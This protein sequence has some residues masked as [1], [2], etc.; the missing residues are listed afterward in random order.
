MAGQV[1]RRHLACEANGAMQ[2][3][4]DANR[5]PY[6]ERDANGQHQHAKRDQAIA[7]G[8]VDLVDGQR[9]LVDAG[10]L[11]IQQ[12]L[13]LGK[14]GVAGGHEL[15]LEH[16]VGFV[17]LA[18]FLELGDLVARFVIRL[19]HG[20]DRFE[21]CLFRVGGQHRLDLVA[22]RRDGVDRTLRFGG[23]E[24]TQAWVGTARH[25]GGAAHARVHQA[26]PVADDALLGQRLLHH[27]MRAAGHVLQPQDAEHG[28]ER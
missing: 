16:L 26:I 11:D 7:H 13:D 15:A 1:A 12:L 21:C 22:Q 9:G 14:I 20:L 28:H 3:R 27:V 6:R 5:E 18:G 10:P 4:G 25:R 17:G 2:R 23:K 24:G 19:A 8:E